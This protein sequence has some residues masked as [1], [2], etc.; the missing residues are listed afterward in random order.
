MYQGHIQ[1]KIGSNAAEFFDWKRLWYD[2]LL[3][4]KKR[5]KS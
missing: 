2:F 4:Y 1:E 3:T 5:E